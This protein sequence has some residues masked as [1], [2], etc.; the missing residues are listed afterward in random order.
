MTYHENNTPEI[1]KAVIYCRVSSTKQ[2]VR[3]DGL[4]SQETRCREF[5]KYKGYE[6]VEVFQDDSSGS[7]TSRP[8]MQAMLAF[9][10]TRRKE[11]HAVIID[12]ISRLARGLMAHF[13]LRVKIGDAGGVL[14]SPSIEFG[15]DSDS[16]LVENLLASVS[17]HQRQKNGE[18]TVNRRR[19]R[20]QNGYWVFQAPI[21]Y[22]YERV[23]GQGKVLV[24]DEPNASALQEALE[25][26]ASGRFETQ[27]EVKRFLERQPSFPKDLPGGEI[28]NQ[29]IYDMLTRVIYAGYIEAPNW[30]VSLRKAQ[31]E[32]LISFETFEKIQARLKGTAKA[33][34]RKD[35]NEDFPLRGFV[36]CDD[37]S[38]PLTACWSQ[39][40]SKKY[41]YY[42]CP[43][44]GCPSYRKSIKR[45]ELEGE[46]EDVLQ[47]LQ[48]T[49]GLFALV[50]A[51]F[52]DAWD[53]RLAQASE[54]T[55][56]VK[57]NIKQIE[58]QVDQLL[59]RIV[60]ASSD[61]VVS[62]Y[63]KRIAKLEREKVLAEEKLAKSGKPRHTFEESFEHAMRFLSNPWSIWKNSD[64]TLKKTVLRLAFVEPLPY[65]RNQGLR[66]PNLA[67]PFKALGDICGHKCEMARW[68][69][70]EPPTP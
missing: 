34:A 41:P 53:M 18:Q 26:Y 7:L 64:L 6:V 70:F 59:D 17:Q 58:K 30:N 13:D 38:K 16:Q 27:V 56:G 20:V 46:F 33:P 12:D 37:C 2:T 29:R 10:S 28:R 21:G 52:R 47:T 51:M 40:K 65:R 61:S 3:G 67:L 23:S 63:E 54:D 4:G 24:R 9:L 14:V 19:A 60:D 49:E 31:H 32:G 35:I 42:L 11:P 8:G 68:G 50:K 43:T 48:P 22:R 55:K 5:A 44:K 36:L 25:G 69:G 66:T 1:S 15:E 45:E 62:A 39:G 57:A